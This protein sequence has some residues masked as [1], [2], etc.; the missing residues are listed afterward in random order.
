VQR[1]ADGTVDLSTTYAAGDQV[2]PA[3]IRFGEIEQ[4]RYAAPHSV[5]CLF[6]GV[7]AKT[8]RQFSERWRSVCVTLQDVVRDDRVTLAACQL[9][10]ALARKCL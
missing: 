5:L 8:I 4:F 6:K 1:S 10:Q 9:V 7:H 3:R 2:T